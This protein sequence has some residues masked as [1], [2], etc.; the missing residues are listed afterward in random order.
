[1]P[2]LV[3]PPRWNTVRSAAERHRIDELQLDLRI[4]TVTVPHHED[5]PTERIALAQQHPRQPGRQPALHPQVREGELVRPTG[6]PLAIF[7]R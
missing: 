3:I 2:S 4:S 5:T 7:G 1:V 6:E